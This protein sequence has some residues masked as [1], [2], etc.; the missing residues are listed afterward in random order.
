MLYQDN[1]LPQFFTMDS[2]KEQIKD[3]GYNLLRV[4]MEH[5][6]V[7]TGLNIKVV[8]NW[9]VGVLVVTEWQTT[10]AILFLCRGGSQP[11]ATKTMKTKKSSII[12]SPPK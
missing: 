4:T 12:A 9:E 7:Y 5:Y 11:R 8:D 6:F 10:I 2:I 1:E 3:F